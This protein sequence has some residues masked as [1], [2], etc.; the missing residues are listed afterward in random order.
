MKKTFTLAAIV[1]LAGLVCAI[2]ASAW[3]VEYN[4]SSGVLPTAAS[5]PW[6]LYR[7]GDPT[8]TISDGVL[9]IQHVAAGNYV[10][11]G[12]ECWAIDRGVPVTMEA[13]MWV[14]AFSGAPRLSIQT[15]GC[16]ADFF[17][18]PDHL[19]AHDWNNGWIPIASSGD[20]STP[21]TIRFA[22]DGGSRAY[23]WV[24]GQMALSFALAPTNGQNG[25]TFGSYGGAASSDSYW[26]YVA[27]SKEFLPVPEPATLIALAPLSLLTGA[28]LVRKRPT[29]RG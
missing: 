7:Y 25:V 18:Y 28:G 29:K 9:R 3:E 21:R 15:Q 13:R 27:Y 4:A 5:P 14:A 10:E 2:K 12:R 19:S 22:Y 26:Q 16:Y 6:K 20:F 24:D 11:Y 23:V 17:I 1:L 8:P